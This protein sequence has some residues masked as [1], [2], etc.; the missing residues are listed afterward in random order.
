MSR[1]ISLTIIF[2][3][4]VV[5]ITHGQEVNDSTKSISLDEVLVT[6]ENVSRQGDHIVILP[7]KSQKDHS[8]TGYALL[9]NLMIPGLTIDGNGSV[10][11]MGMNTGLYING[12]PAD[13]QD[14][15]FLRPNEV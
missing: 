11:T 6:A 4:I 13:V 9:Y 15:V 12:Q 2:L 3:S 10:S 7:T 14:I 8:P 1:S 5:F